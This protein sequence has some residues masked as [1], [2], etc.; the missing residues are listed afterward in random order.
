MQYL[1]ESIGRNSPGL[2]IEVIVIGKAPARQVGI[3]LGTYIARRN[4]TEWKA[5]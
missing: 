3:Y 5:S 1:G 4:L 2:R